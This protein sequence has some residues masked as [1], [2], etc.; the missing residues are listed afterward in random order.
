MAAST[1]LLATGRQG[2][3]SQC[4]AL[5]TSQGHLDV[6]GSP[7]FAAREAWRRHLVREAALPVGLSRPRQSRSPTSEGARTWSVPTPE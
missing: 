4:H 6:S 3:R 1:V 7:R 2:H 5:A